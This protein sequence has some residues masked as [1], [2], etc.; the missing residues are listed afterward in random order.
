[1]KMKERVIAQAKNNE[2]KEAAKL[3]QF[4]PIPNTVST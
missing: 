4:L 3:T 2:K 1:M